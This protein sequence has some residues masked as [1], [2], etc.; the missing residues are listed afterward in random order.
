MENRPPIPPGRGTAEQ[1]HRTSTCDSTPP[2]KLPKALRRGWRQSMRT[3]AWY[4]EK[5]DW[6]AIVLPDGDG[7][8]IIVRRSERFFEDALASA[9]EVLE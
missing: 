3:Q 6:C 4:R 9:N 8:R 7:Y 1:H 5:G 2:N